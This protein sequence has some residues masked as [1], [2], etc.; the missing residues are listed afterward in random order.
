M[1]EQAQWFQEQLDNRKIRCPQKRKLMTQDFYTM[2]N[3]FADHKGF[4]YIVTLNQGSWIAKGRKRFA[5]NEIATSQE[6]QTYLENVLSDKTDIMDT[7]S[8][9]VITY[10][11]K[12]EYQD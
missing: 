1:N 4:E 7:I 3:K 10:L 6:I 5:F 12:E 11:P 9:E 8:K 2:D